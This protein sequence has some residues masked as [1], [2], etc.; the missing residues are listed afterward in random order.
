M[1]DPEHKPGARRLAE[2]RARIDSQKA[3]CVF[4]EL[5]FSKKLPDILVSGTRA[6]S[7]TLDPIGLD[8][9]VGHPGINIE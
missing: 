4:S 2:I 5:Q 3:R 1:V 6:R 7:A 9:P 8:I